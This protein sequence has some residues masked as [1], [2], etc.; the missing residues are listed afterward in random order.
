[1]VKLA[2]SV[3]SADFSKLG[4][5]IAAVEASGVVDRIHIDVM[6][7]MFVPNITIGPLVVEAMRPCSR[8]PFESHLMIAAPDRYVRQFVAAGSDI[9]IVHQEAC[10]HLHRDIQLI[11]ELGARAGVALNPAT[12]LSSI[13]DV[14]PDLDIVVL[15]TVNPGFGGQ[16]FIS[17]T[18]PKIERLRRM[19][20]E[21]GLRVEI[22]VDGGVTASLAPRVAAAG[23]N[24]LVAGSAVFRHPSGPANAAIEIVSSVAR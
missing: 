16:R 24:V 5:E 12:P 22:E 21:A 19:L 2:P 11:K 8:L 9:V 6:D 1:M 10:P 15:M 4:Q 17:T 18:L 7:G 14:L 23:A 13:A 3:L 20:D